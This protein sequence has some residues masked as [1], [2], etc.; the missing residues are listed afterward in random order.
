[1]VPERLGQLSDA[2]IEEKTA[3]QRWLFFY[4]V[5]LD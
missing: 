2:V 5:E 3:K 1:M 4:T